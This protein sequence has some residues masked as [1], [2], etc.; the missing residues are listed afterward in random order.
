MSTD[1]S[2]GRGAQSLGVNGFRPGW[3]SQRVPA[4]AQTTYRLSFLLWGD[5]NGPPPSSRL[6]VR[7]NLER[8]RTLEIDL[9][10]QPTWRRVGMLVR[11]TEAGT[12]GFPR[13]ERR[14][15]RPRH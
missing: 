11:S 1:W 6:A 10:K 15:R 12:P 2:P 7:W 5:P 13:P 14:K 9:R 8:V 4:E 3:I